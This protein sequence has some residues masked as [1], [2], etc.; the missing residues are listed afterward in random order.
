MLKKCT[1]DLDRFWLQLCVSTNFQRFSSG[2]AFPKDL[3][4]LKASRTDSSASSCSL[5][6]QLDSDTKENMQRGFDW[7]SKAIY[8][9]TYTGN[10]CHPWVFSFC[11]DCASYRN[12]FG[13]A[14]TNTLSVVFFQLDPYFF[15]TIWF[16]AVII[17]TQTASI[18]GA[19]FNTFFC[20]FPGWPYCIFLIW[21]P[22]NTLWSW[23]NFE[24][25]KK[26]KFIL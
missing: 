5:V 4:I 18:L 25:K 15:I 2:R 22:L 20:L 3:F 14:N 6:N 21:W 1:F 10:K 12:I 16:E 7:T 8:L 9:Q 23:G 17:S 11:P 19:A 13:L 26:V 24:E